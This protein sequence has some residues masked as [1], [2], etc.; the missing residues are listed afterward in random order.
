MLLLPSFLL[1]LMTPL[2]VIFFY[3]FLKN[4]YSWLVAEKLVDP[5][6]VYVDYPGEVLL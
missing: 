3:L 6:D 1:F 4:G 5:D 2:K